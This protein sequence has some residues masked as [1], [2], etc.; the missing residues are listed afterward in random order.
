[1]KYVFVCFVT[2]TIAP[3]N[4]INTR[5]RSAAN[6]CNP[7]ERPRWRLFAF[8]ALKTTLCSRLFE[9]CLHLSAVAVAVSVVVTVA[10][11]VAVTVA[12]AIAVAVAV[13]VAV[14]AA[15]AVAGKEVRTLPLNESFL[16]A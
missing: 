2:H 6:Q 10:V 7:V 5:A 11:I 8:S 13:D 4:V 16:P 14:D 12:V 9:T 3:P 15:V 1:M